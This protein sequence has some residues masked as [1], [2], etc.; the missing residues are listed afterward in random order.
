MS[1]ADGSGE[2]F[3]IGLADG[4]DNGASGVPLVSCFASVV[5]FAAVDVVAALALRMDAG[6]DDDLV[7]ASACARL[8]FCFNS[9][10]SAWMRC[11]ILSS[12]FSSASFARSSAAKTL[13]L[14]KI[15]SAVAASSAARLEL[16]PGLNFVASKS[17]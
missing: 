11:S 1:P 6:R 12:F 15:D 13:P 3:S 8:S 17:V 2:R 14:L 4:S 9:A 5:P 7:P 10:S 16:R